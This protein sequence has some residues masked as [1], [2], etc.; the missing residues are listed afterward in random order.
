MVVTS[1]RSHLPIVPRLKASVG[2]GLSAVPR[3]VLVLFGVGLLLRIL[4]MLLYS[5]V[6]LTYYGGDSTRYMRLPFTGFH[7]LFSDA[8]IPAGYPAFLHIVRWISNDIALT[9]GLQHLMGIGTAAFLLL[10][11]RR[12]GAPWWAASVPAAVALLS[13]DHLFLE[14]SILT[15]TLWMLLL[16]AAIWTTFASSAYP[17]SRWRLVA[18]GVLF[19]VSATVRH[20]SLPFALFVAVWVAWDHVGPLRERLRVAALLLV[21]ALIVLGCYLGVARLEHGYAGFTDMSGFNLYGRVAGFA[22]CKDFTPPAGTRGLCNDVPPG[23][24]TEGTFYYTYNPASPFYRAGLVPTTPDASIAG[25][26]ARAAIEQQPLQYLK[27]V[28]K[29]LARYVAPYAIT[30]PKDSGSSPGGMSFAN[31]VPQNQ[32]ATPAQLASQYS[33]EYSQVDHALPSQGIREL[34]GG[35]QEIFRL[36]GFAIALLALTAIAGLWLTRDHIR[37]GLVLLMVLAV[38]LYVAP[39]ALSSYDVRYGVPPGL[40]LAAAAGIG[41]WGAVDR[42]RGRPGRP[43]LPAG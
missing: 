5:D 18:A 39:V 21:P 28:V 43:P 15:E 38:Y 1:N 31:T 7:G 12:L 16:A 9:T 27:T 42:L 25:R 20:I 19:A 11:L 30:A 8:S 32:G 13:G 24:R 4:V 2:R 34:L 23:R 33:V 37:R 36:N 35:Y 14:A 40:I 3:T 26:F 29:D 6:T 17:R 10:A 41:A 22:N